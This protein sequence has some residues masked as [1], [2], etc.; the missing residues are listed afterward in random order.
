MSFAYD[1]TIAIGEERVFE[2]F[3]RWLRERHVPDVCAAGGCEGEIVLSDAPRVVVARYRFP[4]RAA[5]QAYE[6]EH[7]PRLRQEGLDVLAALGAR[8][9]VGVDFTRTT[10]EILTPAPGRA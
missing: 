10:G 7:A 6:R 9:G 1:V 3:L 2:A 4:S 8:P 5:F